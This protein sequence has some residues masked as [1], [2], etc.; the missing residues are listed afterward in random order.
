MVAILSVRLSKTEDFTSEYIQEK[1]YSL[2]LELNFVFNSDYRLR[3]YSKALKGFEN[4]IRVK[5]DH[6]LAYYFAAKCY[7]KLH[8]K[9]KYQAYKTKYQEIIQS[10]VFWSEYAAAFDLPPLV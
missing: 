2:N 3:N 9:D 8:E 4:T 1:A 10:S 6:A 7:D 5:N